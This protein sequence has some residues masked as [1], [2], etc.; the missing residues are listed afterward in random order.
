MTVNQLKF[1]IL[2][3]NKRDIDYLKVILKKLKLPFILRTA[4]ERE[5]YIKLLSK[6]L[7]DIIIS[8]YKL[9]NFTG[10]DALLIAKKNNASIKFI[11]FTSPINE[12]TAVRCLKK[13]AW[14]YI[15]K[16]KSEKLLPSIRSALKFNNYENLKKIASDTIKESEERY[17]NFIEQSYEGIFR[18]ELKRPI[19]VK[20]PESRQ[21]NILLKSSFI[22]ECNNAMA[23]MHGFAKPA[24]MI[25]LDIA[26]LNMIV[27]KKEH[28]YYKQFVKNN[29]S[30]VNAEIQELDRKGNSKY[31]LNN[32]TGTVE[33][34]KLVRI[35][36]VQ[37]DITKTKK[38]DEAL[39]DSE[40]RF[41][42]LF[43]N[44]LMGIYQMT[45][46]GKLILANPSLAGMLGYSTVGELL[47]S[48]ANVR[49]FTNSKKRQNFLKQFK[50]KDFI[51]GY[52]S[53]WKRRDANKIVVR[54]S[55]RAAKDE[56]GKIIYFEGVVEDISEKKKFENALI[57]SEERFS[58]M[59]DTAPIMIWIAG[60]NKLFFY[61]NKSWLDFTG[62]PIFDELGSRWMDNIHHDDLNDFLDNYNSAF[63]LKKEFEIVFRLKRYDDEY[64]WILTRGIP[65]FFSDGDF[66]GFIGTAIDITDRKLAE[67]ALKESEE[68]Y[69]GVGES[70]TEGL[71]ITDIDDKI[72]F[73]NKR[74]SEIIGYSFEEMVGKQGFKIFFDAEQWK[75]ILNK[76]KK[77][78]E[79]I[80]DIYEIEMK[81][82]DGKKIWV[83]ISGFPYRN[84]SGKIIGTIG[85]INDI[86]L[87]KLAEKAIEESEEKY[88][89]VVENIR[90]V[91]FKTDDTGTFTFLSPFWSE[92]TGYEPDKCLGESLF[93][94]IHPDDKKKSTDEFISIIY[95]KKDYCRFE[96]KAKVKNGSYRWMEINARIMIDRESNILGTYG[97]FND[98]HE[99]R[100]AEEELIKAKDRAEESD[101]L[102]SIFLAQI[103]HEI[104]TPLNIIL[105]Y[106]S[107]IKERLKQESGPEMDNEFQIIE[108][109]GKRLLRTIDLIL[110]MSL[111]Q[112]GSFE[113][114]KEK[115]DLEKLIGSLFKEF[116]AIAENK[117]IGLDFDVKGNNHFISGDK[118]TL[119]QAFQ[120]LI[121][122][123]IKFTVEGK[124]QIILY[125]NEND[126]IVNVTDTGIGISK[127]FL[128][129]LFEP[130][131]QEE[132]GYSRRYEGNGLGLALTKKY[133]EL[134]EAAI[135]VKSTK[136]KGTIFSVKFKRKN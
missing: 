48:D 6:F 35:W 107:L 51:I 58:L 34:G 123:A 112:T 23:R 52:Q 32:I 43:N 67:D 49:G 16:N 56:N 119:T 41:K 135:D 130:F 105:G 27:G 36:G 116:K 14:D 74:M 17:R 10:L 94:F 113:I 69:K 73:T 80:S 131:S 103:S 124:V 5:S 104:R 109:S 117:T 70:W 21:L 1:L 46:N 63:K 18:V 42:L 95:R 122:N 19:D 37:K 12:L 125:E 85:A 31:F 72:L 24:D 15:P 84:S 26:K 96:C 115:I 77:R 134:N 39:R 120:N 3:D 89:S 76:N 66:I 79:N 71:M 133:I 30:I 29:Y 98:V 90:E 99:R 101:R 127:D 57:E 78:F 110:N 61:L 11:F 53:E 136:G 81:R 25:G 8:R 38:V 64:R 47:L 92:V 68:L 50:E 100:L 65:R 28:N 75:T 62:R 13:G 129:R 20:L 4:V 86:S 60:P 128:P 111:V 97:T 88:R 126:I 114:I 22:A 108:N 54:E 40:E 55:T 102:K 59:A 2:E 118:Y 83:S 9:L 93:D 44:L 82:K 33:D 132:E 7:P 91:I 106:N 45:P 121:D 87:S